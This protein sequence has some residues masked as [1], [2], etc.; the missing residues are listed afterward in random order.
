MSKFPCKKN[1]NDIAHIV[2][3]A[4]ISAIPW[5]GGPATELFTAVITPSLEKRRIKWL[6]SLAEELERLQK[7]VGGFS[8]EEIAKNEAFISS[9]LQASQSALR[10]NQEEKLKALRNAVLNSLKPNSPDEDQQSMFMFYIDTLTP[11]HLRILSFFKNPREWGKKN[12]T[13]YPDW[14]AG[15]P[16]TVLEHTFSELRGKR[17]FYDQIVKDLYSRGL[18]SIDQLHTT[19][20]KNGMFANRT[21]ELGSK[22]INFIEIN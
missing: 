4:G 21:T 5:L 17:E 1:K 3:K 20:T 18:M 7:E 12:N 13:E 16:S 14:S 2:S 10:T 15:G 8:Y 19:M 22:F 6:N 11:W 9:V